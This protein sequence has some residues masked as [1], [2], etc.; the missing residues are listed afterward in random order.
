MELSISYSDMRNKIGNLISCHQKISC[1]KFNLSIKFDV[2]K[3]CI[4]LSDKVIL[5]N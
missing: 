1:Y 5:Y 4:H 3:K 2:A